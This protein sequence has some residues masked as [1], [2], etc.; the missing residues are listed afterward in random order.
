MSEGVGSA[1]DPNREPSYR[2]GLPGWIK[3]LV[4]T[5]MVA[6]VYHSAVF[7]L[8]EQWIQEPDYSH[9]FFVPIVSAFLVWTRREKLRHLRVTPSGWGTAVVAIALAALVAGTVGAELFLQ[10]TSLIV[11]I[12]GLVL[13]LRG[14]EF[15]RAITFPVAFLIFM[16]PL[17]AIV[18]DAIAFPLQMF[19][20][21]AAT[22]CLIGLG[23]PVLREGNVIVLSNTTLEVAEACSG[24][25]SLHTLAG[26]AAL[27]AYFVLRSR[28]KQGL[29]LFLTVPIAIFANA[30]RVTG[31]GILA[32]YW[33][34]QVADGFYH[35]LSSFLVFAI[36]FAML[37]G[38]GV[39][40]SRLRLGAWSRGGA[41]AE[42]TA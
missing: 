10:R 14:W 41:G 25:R 12:A 29:L 28:W 1:L 20:A 6:V 36:A 21:R 26:M 24:I 19:A 2:Q 5:G 13:V 31:T 17:P 40:L 23:V 8:V 30:F 18:M 4:L 15:L 42:E 35:G 34:M 9:G 3:V 7:R 16:V 32:R 11:L 27:Y 38:G 33:G 37:L 22:F 39:V